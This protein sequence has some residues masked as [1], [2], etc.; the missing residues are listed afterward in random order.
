MNLL[1]LRTVLEYLISKT[2]DGDRTFFDAAGFPWILRVEAEWQ[3]IAAELRG[4]LIFDP[5]R[6][7]SFQDLSY[8]QRVLTEGDH[9]KTFFFFAYGHRIESNCRKCP[10]TAR[11]VQF[12]PGMRTAMFSILAPG[13]RL[14]AHRG[15]YKGV[16][17]YH[18]GLIVPAPSKCGIRVGNDI[19]RWEE[20]KSLVFDDSHVHEAWN[21]SDLPRVVLFVDFLRPLPTPLGALNRRMV[22]AIAGTGPVLSAVDRM[23]RADQLP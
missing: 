15:L 17:R 5:A 4:L 22:H 8:E 18:L 21:Q 14:P 20:G 16:L 3:T 23:R 7:P 12:I 1:R 6:I 2:R 13:K 9:W 11:I 19:R 10:E